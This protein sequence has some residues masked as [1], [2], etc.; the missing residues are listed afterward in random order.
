MAVRKTA[1]EV[2][3]SSYY[4]GRLEPLAKRLLDIAEEL[5]GKKSAQQQREFEDR[6]ERRLQ[7]GAKFVPRKRQPR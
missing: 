3:L 4:E 7:N 1:E 2:N 5:L 6:I